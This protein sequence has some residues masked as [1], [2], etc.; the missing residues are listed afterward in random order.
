MALSQALD[1]QALIQFLKQL[2]KYRKRKIILI[3]DNLRVHHSKL[4]K[5]WVEDK[6]ERIK[7]VYLP[8]YS[9]ELNPD[10]YLNQRITQEN[11]KSPR[12]PQSPHST[13]ASKPSWFTLRSEPK[14]SKHVF[15]ILLFNMLHDFGFCHGGVIIRRI[16]Q[17]NRYQKSTHVSM[18]A[19]DET[20]H[21]AMIFLPLSFVHPFAYLECVPHPHPPQHQ[22]RNAIK[23]EAKAP[24]TCPIFILDPRSIEQLYAGALAANSSD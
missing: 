14:T 13:L 2:I 19:L 9:P 18:D 15:S 12:P 21:L 17:T 4:V 22:C 8:S 7:L 1:A 20:V 11:A 16:P 10:E 5:A 6:K 23:R 3:V 24:L